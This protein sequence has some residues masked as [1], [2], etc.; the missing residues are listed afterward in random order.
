MSPSMADLPL[1]EEIIGASE[2]IQTVHI[3]VC[4]K[5]GQTLEGIMDLRWPTN[6]LVS[7]LS[8]P[9]SSQTV[10]EY[11]HN[12]LCYTYDLAN[13]SQRVTRLVCQKEVL[14]GRFYILAFQEDTLPVHRFP[15]IDEIEKQKTSKT[16]YRINNRLTLI[17][18]SN[19][20]IYFNYNHGFNVDVKKIQ[21]DLQRTITNLRFT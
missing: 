18:E 14:Q 11:H 12:D 15:C 4:P 21:Y 5:A 1:L 8:L 3:Y 20:L 10:W 2:A 7:S 9:T 13:D 6:R 16:V 17:H 19:G